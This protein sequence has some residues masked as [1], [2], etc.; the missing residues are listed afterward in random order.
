MQLSFGVYFFEASQY[1][2]DKKDNDV[3]GDVPAIACDKP[4]K[5]AVVHILNEH[6]KR[7]LI[8]VAEMVLHNIR[9]LT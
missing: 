2:S 5:R 6:E 4:V 3:F 9:R 1:F 7:S 8:V